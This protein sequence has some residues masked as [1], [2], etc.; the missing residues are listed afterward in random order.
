MEWTLAIQTGEEV[1]AVRVH[2]LIAVSALALA[3]EV[4]REH[5][6]AELPL[7]ESGEDTVGKAIDFGPSVVE[8]KG[9]ASK[10]TEERWKGHG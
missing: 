5:W 6:E 8:G 7:K 9:K 1:V 4:L 10:V 3:E 2:G